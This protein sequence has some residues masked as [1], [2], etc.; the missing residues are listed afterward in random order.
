LKK[1]E[2]I[3][4]PLSKFFLEPEYAFVAAAEWPDDIK[5]QNWK[6]FNPLHFL[7]FPVIDPDFTGEIHTAIDNATV[8]F[9]ECSKILSTSS[10][11][12]SVIGK[13]MCMRLII[14]IVGDIHQPLH[15]ATL[16]SKEFPDGDR[17]GNQFMI[18]YPA[19]KYANLH[20]YWD[21][22]AHQWGTIKAVSLFLTKDYELF[23][24][25]ICYI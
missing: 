25:L 6:S 13:S 3:L 21:D 1:A 4:E 19:K 9:N 2:A 20:A 17:G 5:G 7:N 12:L 23:A 11:D 8:A 10:G 14:H 24:Y 22:T 15:S 18:K 16:F